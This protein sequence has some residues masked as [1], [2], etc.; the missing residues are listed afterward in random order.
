MATK[1]RFLVKNVQKYKNVQNFEPNFSRISRLCNFVE[2]FVEISFAKYAGYF[3]SKNGPCTTQHWIFGSFLAKKRPNFD[4]LGSFLGSKRPISTSKVIF[5]HVRK[6]V[7]VNIIVNPFDDP[8]MTSKDL[9]TFWNIILS[10]NNKILL[11]WIFLLFKTGFQIKQIKS[12]SL[13]R[14]LFWG[15]FGVNLGQMLFYLV[16]NLDKTTF[17]I[18]KQPHCHLKWP[19]SDLNS[20]KTD[21]KRK[22]VFGKKTL[23]NRKLVR[24]C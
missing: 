3:T 2:N 21:R 17:F 10:L 15:H 24:G 6:Q 11:Y 5:W 14:L 7:K 9:K 19:K 16:I 1:R 22:K 18:S 23:S 8:K 4:A 13:F 12:R 20:S